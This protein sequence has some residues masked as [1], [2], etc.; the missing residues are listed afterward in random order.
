MAV[1]DESS[2][3][4]AHQAVHDRAVVEEVNDLVAR[5]D[6]T[7]FPRAFPVDG[8]DVTCGRHPVE[9][10]TPLLVRCGA[11]QLDVRCV[12]QG[13]ARYSDGCAFH[14]DDINRHVARRS[15]CNER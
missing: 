15:V 3:P 1:T 12:Q 4:Y 5:A 11:L 13:D 14:I 8:D 10:Q 2:T 7:R 6:A 9:R